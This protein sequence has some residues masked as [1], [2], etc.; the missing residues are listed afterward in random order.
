MAAFIG[1]MNYSIIQID[2]LDFFIN[3]YINTVTASNLAI[4]YNLSSNNLTMFSNVQLSYTIVVRCDWGFCGGFI[5]YMLSVGNFSNFNA[6][7]N[8]QQLMATNYNNTMGF[9]IQNKLEQNFTNF[10]VSNTAW[11]GGNYSGTIVAF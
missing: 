8:N 7:F 11:Q 6:S 9:I 5:G 3:W 4:I 2:K 10:K 1:Q